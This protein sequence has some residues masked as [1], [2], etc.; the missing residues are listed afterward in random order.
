MFVPGRDIREPERYGVD[1]ETMAE[2]VEGRLQ[3][4]APGRL[5]RRAHGIGLRSVRR[6][7]H[8]ART[9]VWTGVDA[10]RGEACRIRIVG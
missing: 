9:H 1:A 3:G 7:K 5:A 6:D 8:V 4:E 2:F 10:A